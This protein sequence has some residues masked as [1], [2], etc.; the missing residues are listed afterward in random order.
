LG[1]L[2]ILALVQLPSRLKRIDNVE[3]DNEIRFSEVEQPMQ[4]ESRAASTTDSD[5]SL[6]FKSAIRDMVSNSSR[7]GSEKVV[8]EVSVAVSDSQSEGIELSCH[9]I[10]Y[11]SES[12]SPILQ[13]VW[14]VFPASSFS[15]ILGATNSGKSSLLHILGGNITSINNNLNGEISNFLYS[16]LL[17]YLNIVMSTY[18]DV[19]LLF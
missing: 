11:F 10:N 2:F 13:N 7:G 6:T 3:E 16:A 1:T 4:G 15:A 9:S 5:K 12:G 8:G 19:L 14:G 17:L 18:L